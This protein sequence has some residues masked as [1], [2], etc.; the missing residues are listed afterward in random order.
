[1][2]QNRALTDAVRVDR[3][4][5]GDAYMPIL[6]IKASLVPQRNEHD[7]ISARPGLYQITISKDGGGGSKLRVTVT[8]TNKTTAGATA[9]TT[10]HVFDGAAG[11]SGTPT[12]CATLKDLIDGLNAIE[13]ITA[14]AAHAPHSLSLATNDFIDAAIAGIRTDNKFGLCLYRDV[15]EAGTDVKGNASK[16]L[17]Y[18]RIGNPELRDSGYLRLLGVDGKAT[19]ATNGTLRLLRD[20]YGKDK[21][22]LYEETLAEAQTAYVTNTKDN[23]DSVQCPLLLEVASDDLSAADYIVK[24]MQGQW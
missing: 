12:V 2:E 20:A 21:E 13:G 22:Y 14:F 16:I 10:T 19:G 7:N 11:G 5:F 1:M 17:C 8:I 6:A 4:Q 3:M 15:S 23:A 24:T 18:M 9:S